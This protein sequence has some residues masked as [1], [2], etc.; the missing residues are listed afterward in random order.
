MSA[1]ETLR[2]LRESTP[3][4]TPTSVSASKETLRAETNL[5]G[6]LALPFA[7][8]AEVLANVPSEPEWLWEGYLAPGSL[9]LL[10]GRPKVG[11]STLLFGLLEAL[12]FG[13]TFAGRSTRQASAV[14]LSEE[15][16]GTLKQKAE[17]FSLGAVDLLMAHDATDRAWE[18]VVAQAAIKCLEASASLLLV[19]TLP[20][21][22]R[23]P[24]DGE[25]AA[26]AILA[27]VA[28]LQE[29]ASNGVAVLAAAHQRKSGG[30]YGE[31]VRGSNALT[32][33]VD[34]VL[35]LERH[36]DGAIRVLRAVS[37]YDSTPTELA[38]ELTERGYEAS[39]SLASPREADEQQRLIE[40]VETAASELTV[41]DLSDA[42]GIPQGTVRKR[43]NALPAGTLD[44]RGS[45]KRNDPYLFR[46]T[47]ACSAE[48][49]PAAQL[50]GPRNGA[51]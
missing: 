25:N 29:A 2:L 11:K 51:T 46:T 9:T 23:I 28:P 44:R 40:V 42:T 31:A 6:S 45:G 5:E 13:T 41:A 20:A 8:L 22:A 39:D 16:H 34:I 24:A 15:R 12:R 32:G 21:W 27:A 49:K 33:A 47:E 37:R 43:L 26:G 17:R 1:E 7:P 3:L 14:L 19:D 35:E 10:A 18:E 36:G 30:E 50:A 4:L 38:L 48:T